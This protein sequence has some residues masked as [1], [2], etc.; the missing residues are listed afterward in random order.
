MTAAYVPVAL[1]HRVSAR[2][3]GF[4]E[5]CL[6]HEA[7]TNFSCEAEHIISR[8]HGSETTAENL[9]LACLPCNRAKGSDIGSL[10]H[11][12]FTR[13][14]NPRI[15]R[16]FDHFE[17]A[18]DGVRIGPLSDIGSATVRIFGFNLPER[19]EERAFLRA[20]VR[21]PLPGAQLRIE[22]VTKAGG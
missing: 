15:D 14:F 6:I 9:A 2:A 3:R 4:C 8:K 11:D 10:V 16:W 5:Y 18:P 20:V 19:L 1:R 17:L 22:R 12:R 21:Y 13:F 7:D